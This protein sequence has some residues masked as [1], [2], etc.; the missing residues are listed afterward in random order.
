MFLLSIVKTCNTKLPPFLQAES[1]IDGVDSVNDYKFPS[2]PHLLFVAARVNGH[3]MKIMLDT[4]ANYSF[5]NATHLQHYQNDFIYHDTNHRRFVLADGVSSMMIIGKTR[6]T[7]NFGDV[8]TTTEVFVSNQLCTDLILGMNF[9]STYDLEIRPSKKTII[10]HINDKHVTVPIITMEKN[11]NEQKSIRSHVILMDPSRQDFDN[12]QISTEITPMILLDQSINN[13]G[14]SNSLQ[15]QIN[16]LI[17]HINDADQHQSLNSLLSR[18]GRTFDTSQY[19]TARTPVSHIIETHP[20]TPPI[21]KCYISTPS[22][23]KEM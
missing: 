11:R 20:H 7:I 1:M 12:S 13:I 10:F 16:K 14:T 6:L 23:I 8:T 2:F 15:Q 22:L 9:L 21:S 19:T 4:G 17:E 3:P 5:I 18:S